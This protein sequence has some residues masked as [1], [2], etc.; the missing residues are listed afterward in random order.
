MEIRKWENNKIILIVFV[1]CN[2]LNCNLLRENIFEGEYYDMTP[3][4]EYMML[5]IYDII[6]RWTYEVK[7]I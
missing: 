3:S 2:T 1:T 6:P 7:Y 5:N 4:W